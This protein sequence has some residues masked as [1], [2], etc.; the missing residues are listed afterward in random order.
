MTG[1]LIFV[2]G[3][4]RTETSL[5]RTLGNGEKTNTF[6]FFKQALTWGT[7]GLSRRS[8]CAWLRS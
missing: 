1:T 6:Y 2:C 7:W 8:L 5:I 3:P 4:E